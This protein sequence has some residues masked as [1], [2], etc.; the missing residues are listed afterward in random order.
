LII[1]AG[2]HGKVVADTALLCGWE[3]CFIDD[4]A[5]EAPGPLGLVVIGGIDEI[6][7]HARAFDAAVVAI[8]AAPRRLEVQDRCLREGM[9]VATVIHPTAVVSR[10]ATLGEGTVVFANAVVNAG[11]RMGRA[12][13]VNTAATIDH[14]CWLGDGVH[15]CPGTHLAGNVSIGDR[16]W[17]GIGSAVRQRLEIGAD[18]VVG[19]GA[20]V[21][22]DVPSG[23]TVVG[24][25][26][27]IV[28]TSR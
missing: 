24:V 5:G 20:A 9:A 3:V 2:G 11:A 13:I 10:H 1:G 21:V 25:P 18:A 23:K 6:P 4:R 12:C 22:A 15:V 26:A 17:I 14:D 27:R 19:A 7:S 28:G 8:G 16:A